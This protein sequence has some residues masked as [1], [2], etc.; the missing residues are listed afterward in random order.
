MDRQ[1]RS[2]I[3]ATIGPSSGEVS[4]IA[5]MIAVYSDHIEQEA[6][7]YELPLFEMDTDFNASLERAM[8]HLK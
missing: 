5:R 2:Q 4:I 6:K 8:K 3:I 1:S 7:K